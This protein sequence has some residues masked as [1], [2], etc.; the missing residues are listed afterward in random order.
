MVLVNNLN[1]RFFFQKLLPV[2]MLQIEFLNNASNLI[3]FFKSPEGTVFLNV[4]LNYTDLFFFL[5]AFFFL[6]F[7]VNL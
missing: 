5:T 2:F 1:F 4:S 6:Y 7:L 3:F